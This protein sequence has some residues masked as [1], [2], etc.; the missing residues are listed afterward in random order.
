ML[1]KEVSK[2]AKE[3][4]PQIDTIQQRLV[5]IGTLTSQSGIGDN[6]SNALKDL[7]NIK[8]LPKVKADG[9]KIL[10]G[11]DDDFT[12]NDHQRFGDAFKSQFVLLDFSIEE[13]HILNTLFGYLGLSDK[14]LSHVVAEV[15]TVSEDAGEDQGLTRA[16]RYKAHALYW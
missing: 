4:P 16:F 6:V 15:S 2:M 12:I 1:I 8:F 11:K 7:A 5:G 14:Y 10:V 9:S 13:V 3:H